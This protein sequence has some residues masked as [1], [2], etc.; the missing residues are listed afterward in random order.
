MTGRNR[1]LTA[2]V[3]QC[4][5]RVPISTYELVGFNRRSFENLDPSYSRLM[6]AIRAQTDCICMWDPSSNAAL[7]KTDHIG[8]FLET[9]SH[10]VD[11]DIQAIVEGNL[12]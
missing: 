7:A 8:D 4:A 5:D 1:I 2:L 11:M 6:D 10:T 12:T 9:T 3:H